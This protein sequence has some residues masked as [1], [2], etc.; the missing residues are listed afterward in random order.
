MKIEISFEDYKTVREGMLE[1]QG[2]KMF[3][4]LVKLD[5]QI[6]SQLP[7]SVKKDEPEGEKQNG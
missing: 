4:L 1:L 6:Y 5:Q 7:G 2:K 3:D